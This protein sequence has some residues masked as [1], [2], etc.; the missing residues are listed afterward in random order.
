M[1]KYILAAVVIGSF[2]APA[3]AQPATGPWFVG[4]DSATGKC[5]VVSGKMPEGMKMMG[6]YKT[7]DEAKT[8]MA[9]MK[10]CKA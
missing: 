1:K 3:F 9:S 10:E 5:S 4:L 2:V 8:A 6:E 7:E